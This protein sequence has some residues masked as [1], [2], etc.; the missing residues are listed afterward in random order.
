MFIIDIQGFQ[1]EQSEFIIR[2]FAIKNIATGEFFH[3]I[4][5][6]KSRIEW[7]N[8]K[9]RRHM[10]FTTDNIHGLSWGCSYPEYLP[11]ENIGLFMKTIISDKPVFVKGLNKKLALEKFIPNRI[12]DLDSMNCPKLSDLNETC[13]V[14]FHCY[15]HFYNHLNCSNANVNLIYKWFTSKDDVCNKT[16]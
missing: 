7:F 9:I 16:K 10:N 3:K 15:L 4:T 5:N 6:L 2:E 8:E 13:D 12:F 11:Y 1:F 14:N